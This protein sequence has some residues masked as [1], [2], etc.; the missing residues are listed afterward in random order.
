MKLMLVYEYSRAAQKT[1]ES[2]ILRNEKLFVANVY[3]QHFVFSRKSIHNLPIGACQTMN[4][5]SSG[6]CSYIWVINSNFVSE[7][8]S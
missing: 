3:K 8:V 4:W 5:R 6:H 1:R 7:L 2:I